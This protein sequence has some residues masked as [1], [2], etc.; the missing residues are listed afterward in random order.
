M[1]L[2]LEGKA[3]LVTGASEGIGRAIARKLAG[4]GVRV[5]I[6]ARTEATLKATAAEIA[7]ATGVDVAPIPADLRSLAGCQRV[8]EQAAER[9]GGVDIL[10]NNAGASAF[11]AFVDLPDDAFVDA[12]NGKLLGY[13]RC[14]KA[15]IP[16][17]RRRGGGV[18]VNIT[19]T[20]QQAVPL[21]TP[22][23]ACNAAIRMFS[24]EL[25]MELGPLGIRVNS[26]APGRIQT[27]RADRLLEATA[28][29][30]RTSPDVLLGQLVKTIPSGRVGTGDDIA[31][32]VCFLVSD[33]A[34]YINGAALV[35]DGS[36]SLVI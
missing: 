36:K 2:G 15:V 32:A 21:H 30:Q 12:I 35:I 13:I 4:E 6:C 11:G 9:L 8:V 25:S 17:M 3:A 31:D 29:A 28:S 27:A 26:V 18:I 34:G 1:D 10:V 5:A 24:K 20:T 7:E 19:G 23:S 22:G 33:R 14:A 16:H